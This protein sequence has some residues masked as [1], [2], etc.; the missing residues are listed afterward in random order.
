MTHGLLLRHI[1][2]TFLCF[3]PIK[4]N[5]MALQDQCK[6]RVLYFKRF[7]KQF[8]RKLWINELIF[9]IAWVLRYF[10]KILDRYLVA[11]R[12]KKRESEYISPPPLSPHNGHFKMK[13]K[14]LTLTPGIYTGSLFRVSYARSIIY[15][16]VQVDTST[17]ICK[18]SIKCGE[19]M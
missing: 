7:P 9:L 12:T 17:C 2:L 8:W 6:N 19:K 5:V 3:Q 18:V 16:Q 4:H 14:I 11:W 15:A 10:R 13:K 1:D